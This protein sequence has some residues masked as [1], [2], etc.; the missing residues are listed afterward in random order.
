VT[1]PTAAEALVQARATFPV[2]AELSPE[3]AARLEREARV[4]E[5]PAGGRLFDERTPC[6]AFPLVI[7]GRVKVAKLA[8]SGREIVLYRVEPGQSCLITSS[9]LLARRDYSATGTAETDVTLVAMSKDLFDALMAE[10]PVF[11]DY[12]HALFA[13]RIGELML[14]VE[15]VAFRRLDQRL[16]AL[17]LARGPIVAARHQDLAEELGSV[18]E[19]VS[20]LLGDFGDRGLVAL[21]RGRIEIKDRAGLE[22]LAA[23]Q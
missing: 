16:A 20:R 3:L 6:G 12:V 23:A 8:P 21:G 17:L 18:R 7:R 2:L 22:T 14:L 19:I 11:R 9:C 13:E 15:E 1:A 10:S 4:M 5:V